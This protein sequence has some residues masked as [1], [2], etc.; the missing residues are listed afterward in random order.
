LKGKI[1]LFPPV[2]VSLTLL[3][4]GQPRY[5]LSSI[6]QAQPRTVSSWVPHSISSQAA[7]QSRPPD[8]W[9]RPSKQAGRHGPKPN[10]AAARRQRRGSLG[11]GGSLPSSEFRRGDDRRYSARPLELEAWRVEA[12]DVAEAVGG[13][14]PCVLP[15]R[16]TGPPLL[17]RRGTAL[18][19]I[20]RKTGSSKV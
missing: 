18:A 8:T 7:H 15:M 6:Y 13:G 19:A 17:R 1:G 11:V 5:S 16:R 9:A 10:K 14:M 20:D 4:L 12:A 3:W 2:S